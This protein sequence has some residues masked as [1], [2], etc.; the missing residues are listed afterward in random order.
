MHHIAGQKHRAWKA[1]DS[2]KTAGFGKGEAV[3]VQKIAA[4]F[5]PHGIAAEH[6]AKEDKASGAG[7]PQKSVKYRI[8]FTAPKL[9]IR[10][11]QIIKG[12]RVG[13]TV[14]YHKSSPFLAPSKDSAGKPKSSRK[15]KVRRMRKMILCFMVFSSLKRRI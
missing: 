3:V 9:T 1:A 12:R 8:K 14:L 10:F 4:V 11:M 15:L 6:T 2:V 5:G 7:Q 13:R